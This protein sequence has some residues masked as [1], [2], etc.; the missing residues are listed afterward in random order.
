MPTLGVGDPLPSYIY[1]YKEM[2]MVRSPSK[3]E[4]FACCRAQCRRY[5]NTSTLRRS[6]LGARMSSLLRKRVNIASTECKEE[7]LY[8]Y[9]SMLPYEGRLVD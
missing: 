4:G 9:G 3:V 6:C 8:L 7:K 5:S 2:E 1:S